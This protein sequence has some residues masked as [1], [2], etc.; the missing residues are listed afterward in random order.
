[1]LLDDN[2]GMRRFV[3]RLVRGA[4]A[5]GLLG[6]AFLAV[7]LLRF[8]VAGGADGL[9]RADHRSDLRVFTYYVAGVALAGSVINVLQ[10]V[11]PGN[12]GAYVRFAAGGALVMLMIAV[13]DQGGIRALDTIDWIVLPLLG[14]AMGCAMAFGYTRR[15]G[16]FPSGPPAV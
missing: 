10:P 8:F 12:A 13:G 6:C 1:M 11:L 5:G 9:N 7:G 15:G 14:G 16:D 3:V 2:S 4:L